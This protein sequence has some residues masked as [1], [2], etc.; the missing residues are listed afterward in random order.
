[1]EKLSEIELARRG[2]RKGYFAI[3]NGKKVDKFFFVWIDRDRRYL[4][5]NTSS[6]KPGMPYEMDRLRQLDDSPNADPVRV[7]FEI[8]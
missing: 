3:D 8:N 7:E 1:M 2:M 4:I 5:S 6:L